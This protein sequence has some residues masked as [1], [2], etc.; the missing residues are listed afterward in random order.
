MYDAIGSHVLEVRKALRQAGYDSEIWADRIDERLGTEARPYTEYPEDRRGA[1]IYQL[2]TDS[3][4]V[5]W[6]EKMASRG[7]RIASNYHNITPAEYFRRWEPPISRRL[8]VA[9][10]QLGDLARI[11]E[12]GLAVSAYNQSEL[13]QAGYRHTVVTPLL[14]DLATRHETPDD[15]LLNRLNKTPGTRWLFVGRLAP[16]KCQHDVVAAFAVY[17]RLYDP[18]A[19]LTLVGSP[20]SYRYLRA[21]QRLASDIG[22]EESVEFVSNLG[23]R[24]LA[25]YYAGADVFT[26]LSEHEGFCVPLLESMA[27]GLPVVAYDAGA[28]TETLAG[29]GLILDSKDPLEVAVGVY[30]LLGDEDLRSRNVKTG[31]VRAKELSLDVTA[32][33][34]VKVISDWLGESKPADQ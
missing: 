9:R 20:S 32:P 6:L 19:R 24:Q 10:E 33:D 28:V 16:N 3:E 2:S 31:K 22:V 29:S 15:W 30:G 26:C 25:A 17:R 13:D 23:T 12:L 1:L 21:V 8:E 5:P 7:I 4:M 11:T 14:V 27:L 34:F 18:R